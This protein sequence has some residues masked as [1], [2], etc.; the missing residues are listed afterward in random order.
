MVGVPFLQ[1][2]FLVSYRLPH[3]CGVEQCILRAVAFRYDGHY[4]QHLAVL[5][6][7][8][9]RFQADDIVYRLVA[10][11]LICGDVHEA[12]RFR[13]RDDRRYLFIYRKLFHLLVGSLCLY[14]RRSQQPC[15]QKKCR[16]D[17][18]FVHVIDL[19]ILFFFPYLFFLLYLVP[20]FQFLL[21][22]PLGNLAVRL[23]DF[24]SDVV[25]SRAD[26]GHGGCA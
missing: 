9:F 16:Y 7:A 14:I 21:N 23:F 6:S 8:L 19:L 26:S 4:G 18:F 11:N 22:P 20:A 12:Y 25:P 17:S 13:G 10:D 3:P 2:D 24:K 1:L 15:R 5:V